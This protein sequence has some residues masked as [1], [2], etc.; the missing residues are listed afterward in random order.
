MLPIFDRIIF[1]Q[2]FEM[3]ILKSNTFSVYNLHLKWLELYSFFKQTVARVSNP[4]WKTLNDGT[5]QM[6]NG[7]RL[8]TTT[9]TLNGERLTL[10]VKRWTS[11]DKQ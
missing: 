6:L 1:K 8:T 4:T 9:I 3:C 5:F 10:N 7:K 11:N 2:F